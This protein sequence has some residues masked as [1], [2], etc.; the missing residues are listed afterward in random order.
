MAYQNPKQY[1]TSILG[2]SC[3]IHNTN[4]IKIKNDIVVKPKSI[5][6]DTWL[7]IQTRRTTFV[8][9]QGYTI[10]YKSQV[11]DFVLFIVSNNG[12]YWI[13]PKSALSNKKTLTIGKYKSFYDCYAVKST[14]IVNKICDL[15]NDDIKKFSFDVARRPYMII[16][17]PEV[18]NTK[19]SYAMVNKFVLSKDCFL[20]T[21][22][23]EYKNTKEY[24]TVQYA[25]GHKDTVTY[26]SF[27]KRAHFQ[28]NKCLI[29]TYKNNY[30]HKVG[31]L[32]QSV[33]EG[34]TL[35]TLQKILGNEFE[36]KKAHEGCLCD[37]IIRPYNSKVDCWIPI[38]V[39]TNSGNNV[40]QY[41]FSKINKYPNMLVLMVYIPSEKLWMM[42]GSLLTNMKCVSIGKQLSKYSQYEIQN[43][44]LPEIL[45]NVYKTSSYNDVPIFR[46]QLQKSMLPRQ[47]FHQKEHANR[48]KREI[49]IGNLV[50]IQYPPYDGMKYDCTINDM[51]VQ[52]KTCVRVRQLSIL[53]VILAKKYKRGDNDFYWLNVSDEQYSNMFYVLPEQVLLDFGILSDTG[54]KA[55]FC[56]CLKNEPLIKRCNMYQEMNKYL[57]DYTNLDTSMLI[58]LFRQRNV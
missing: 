58:S 8:E 33:Q 55:S 1:L 51:K 32:I 13:I 14:E 30:N 11:I 46:Q 4:D 16:E 48:I 37:V 44:D 38:Q 22:E 7:R 39:K 20:L 27:H 21:K 26:N 2:A 47:Q 43:S 23:E 28:C 19:F 15:F 12:K 34:D 56:V 40:Q 42:N 41:S 31:A 18:D 3:I 45:R 53:Q 25:C 35:L 50:N 24:V 6:D 9:S 36:V 57:F 5:H 29:T 49:A 10:T 54:C 17:S 52:D